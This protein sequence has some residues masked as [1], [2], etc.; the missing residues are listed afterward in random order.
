M[1]NG[2]EQK[3]KGTTIQLGILTLLPASGELPNRLCL[4]HPTPPISSNRMRNPLE[5]S[6]DAGPIQ[7]ALLIGSSKQT[8]WL[9]N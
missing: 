1:N 9:W 2:A 6:P 3:L 5:K 8:S 4:A 7:F